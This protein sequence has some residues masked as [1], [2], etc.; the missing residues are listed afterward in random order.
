MHRRQ[1]SRVWILDFLK[2]GLD[3]GFLPS[4][5]VLFINTRQKSRDFHLGHF[6]MLFD[7]LIKSVLCIFV[8][9]FDYFSSFEHV[10]MLQ[11]VGGR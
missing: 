3:P 6:F 4:S 1:K 7:C 11:K 5:S 8:E 2:D 10:F 9:N